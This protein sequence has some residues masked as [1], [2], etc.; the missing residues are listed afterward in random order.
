[1]P[2]GRLWATAEY[3]F[4]ARFHSLIRSIPHVGEVYA[5][6][7]AALCSLTIARGGARGQEAS[8]GDDPVVATVDGAPVHR[9]EV[10][11]AAR[12]LPDQMRQ[13]PM[14][15]LYG[16]L[17]DR[18]IDF[19]LLADEAERQNV[20]E[21]P[22]VEAALAQAR[23]AVLREFL[24]QQT[25]EE[26][27]TEEKLRALYEEKKAE[28]GFAQEEVHARHILV[29]TEDEAKA[30]IEQLARRRRL[31]R[32]REGALGR[33][34]GARRAAISASSAAT[35]SCPSSP[36]R[37]SPSMPARPRRSRSR[38]SSAGTSS[39]SWSAA[40]S[41]RAYDETAPQL[42]QELA[43]EIVT[44]LVED[45]RGGA[46]IERFNMDG[47]PMRSPRPGSPRQSSPRQSSLRPT[48]AG[49]GTPRRWLRLARRW[50]RRAFRPFRRS[51]A[52]GLPR[53]RPGFATAVVRT[54][55]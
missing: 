52:C 55:R 29:Q 19:R 6:R 50:H 35:R 41:S 33:A 17:L 23:A 20:G 43:R 40:M 18:V 5:E 26:G 38:P 30:A 51:P 24:V 36:R 12:G 49:F 47:S 42:R 25:I 39:T 8:P 2:A 4:M 16:M 48:E 45:L 21:D 46:E 22:A 44:A 9:G 13:M 7:V 53:W 32:G 27:L 11:A 31:R 3:A 37:P 14:Q 1:M 15:M 54:S 28:E 10:E 34:V